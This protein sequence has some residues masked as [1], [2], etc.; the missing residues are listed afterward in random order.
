MQKKVSFVDLIQKFIDEG[1]VVLPVFNTAAMKVQQELVK[2]EPSMQVLINTISGDQSLSSQ[3][4]QMANSSFY[5]G[6]VEVTT[7]KA[8]IVRL[9]MQEVGRI[10]LLA[11]SKNQFHT[12]ESEHKIIMRR[13]WQH[14]VGC[15]M[16]AKWLARRCD[17]K[18]LESEVFFAAL[19]H[20]VGK[21]FVLMV[22]EQIRKK[23][24][25]IKSTS[26]LLNEAMASLHSNQGYNLMKK[27]NIPESYCIVARD[28]HI[29]TF[30]TKNLMLALVR[31]A[32]LVCNKIGVGLK[33]EPDLV[34]SSTEEAQVLNLKELDLAELEILLE[35]TRILTS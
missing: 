2:K 13:L 29:K 15:A 31:V 28:H 19:F 9:G 32:N 21:L 24:K 34:V 17:L 11:S 5:K 4:L 25:T 26:S 33:T 22:V 18:E 8:A 1:D 3:V 27:W 35:D 6:L 14:S 16:G 30:D 23:K 10:G 7:I 20:D 12:R